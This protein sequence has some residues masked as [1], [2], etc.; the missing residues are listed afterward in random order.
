M[1]FEEMIAKQRL[2]ICVGPGGVGKTSVAATLAL[3]GAR[4]GRK[5]LVLTIDPAKRLASALG[6]DGLD[7]TLRRVPVQP[8]EQVGHEVSGELYAAMLDTRS[9][10]DALIMR[11]GGESSESTRRILS[12]RVYQAFSRTLARSHAYVAMERLYD[13]IE[14][15]DFDLI[16]LDTPPT[17]SALDILDAPGR[18]ASFLEDDAVRWFLNPAKGRLRQLLPMGGAAATR[19]LGLLASRKLV[20]ELVAFFSVLLHLREGFAERATRTHEILREATTSFVLVCS[21]STTSLWDA[22][23][24]R[25]GLLERGAP[26]QAALFNR[27]YIP[28]SSEPTTPVR[29]SSQA[30]EPGQRLAKLGGTRASGQAALTLL[31][32]L[33][34]LRADT[35]AF[36]HVAQAAVERFAEHLP[37]GCLKIMLPELD[38]DPRDLLDLT[39]LST[40]LFAD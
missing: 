32:E 35:A 8:L 20:N 30:Q 1:S 12:N 14:S 4:R 11:L 9:S 19:L 10:Y 2:L 27:A 34:K 17:R 26:L 21:P 5:A 15:G 36:N 29:F 18:L 40:P 37:A 13:V 16:V 3:E 23:Y 39:N 38:E 31:H 25:D 24:L 6:L 28:R 33:Q 7:D 22:A